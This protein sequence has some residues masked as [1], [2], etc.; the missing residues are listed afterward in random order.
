MTNAEIQ[1][2]NGELI[3]YNINEPMDFKTFKKLP[4]D[5]AR[6]YIMH[7]HDVYG[8]GPKR[9]AEM[10]HRSSTWV[11]SILSSEPYN[12]K[13]TKRCRMS[14]EQKKAWAVFI[15]GEQ[16]DDAEIE[17]ADGETQNQ[18]IADKVAAF[19][20]ERYGVQQDEDD[21][22]PVKQKGTIDAFSVRFNGCIT[23]TEIANSLRLILG[24]EIEG[25]LDINYKKATD[26]NIS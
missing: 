21:I 25:I 15:G 12:I 6:E 23:I 5:A 26:E 18:A 20:A 17:P 24:G 3:S 19:R 1:K 4:A 11:I 10:F 9:L 7:L 14:A 16:H 8:V 2:M 13:F 22:E